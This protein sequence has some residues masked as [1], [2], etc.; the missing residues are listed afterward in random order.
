MKIWATS[1]IAAVDPQ[2]AEADDRALLLEHPGRPLGDLR[3]ALIVSSSRQAAM[4]A[5]S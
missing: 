2:L 3:A 5:A 1:A 4:K